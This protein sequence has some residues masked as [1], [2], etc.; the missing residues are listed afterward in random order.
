MFLEAFPTRYPEVEQSGLSAP[1]AGADLA[2][3]RGF[4]DV[5]L[6]SVHY[7]TWDT[8]SIGVSRPGHLHNLWTAKRTSKYQ[9]S[10]ESSRRDPHVQPLRLWTSLGHLWTIQIP[11]PAGHHIRLEELEL[12]TATPHRRSRP[13]RVR[14][15][16]RIPGD[17]GR[18]SGHSLANGS[19]ITSIL[20]VT[21]VAGSAET[22]G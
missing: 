17:A 3:P 18:G 15:V 9:M 10:E 2:S 11:H 13:S 20:A 6:E 5:A 22:A 12:A 1:A 21:S 8:Y 14:C 7:F 4:E 16:G 19:L